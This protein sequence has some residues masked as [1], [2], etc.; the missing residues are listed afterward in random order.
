M[1]G[2]WVRNLPISRVVVVARVTDTGVGRILGMVPDSSSVVP[3][4]YGL[5]SGCVLG[6]VWYLF[7]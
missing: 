5:V 1:L 7:V 3:V 6:F 4:G 2:W